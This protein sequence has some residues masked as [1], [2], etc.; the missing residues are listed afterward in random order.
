MTAQQFIEPFPIWHL[1]YFQ[2][3]AIV[4]NVG[5]ISFKVI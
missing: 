1:H 5:M 3:F 2:L 4:N